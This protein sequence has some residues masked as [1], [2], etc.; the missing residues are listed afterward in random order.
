MGNQPSRRVFSVQCTDRK[1]CG[2]ARENQPSP[3]PSP[4][5][6]RG[7]LIFGLRSQGG[8]RSS[9]YPGLQS[10]HSYGVFSLARQARG[11]EGRC[12]VTRHRGCPRWNQSPTRAFTGAAL[13]PVM[14]LTAEQRGLEQ[15][16]A[17]TLQR[18]TTSRLAD[19]L[20]ERNRRP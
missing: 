4:N 13:G 19:S 2:T 14:G 17:R 10:C 20:A 6:G 12:S 5:H 9:A 3:W 7:D 18:D 8:A 15:R 11:G 1:N 16:R